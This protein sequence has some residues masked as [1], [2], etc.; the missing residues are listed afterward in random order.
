MCLPFP[1]MVVK[2]RVKLCCSDHTW[3]IPPVFWQC[4]I[5]DISFESTSFQ[6]SLLSSEPSSRSRT[7]GPILLMTVAIQVDWERGSQASI[8]DPTLNS[9]LG[10]SEA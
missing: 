6:K 7:L 3:S 8:L 2:N 9:F 4:P 5:S 1:Q 10:G